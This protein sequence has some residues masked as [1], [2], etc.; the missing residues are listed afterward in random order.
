MLAQIH[1]C[2][3]MWPLSLILL[4]CRDDKV[5]LIVDNAIIN[6][7]A[8]RRETQLA[9]GHANKMPTKDHVTFASL[10]SACAKVPPLAP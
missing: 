8:R 3:V 5:R 1:S 10:L 9:F 6:L 4:T 7:Y 2:Q